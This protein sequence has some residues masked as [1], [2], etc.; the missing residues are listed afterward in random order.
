[1]ENLGLFTFALFSI[2]SKGN[3]GQGDVGEITLCNCDEE[4]LCTETKKKAFD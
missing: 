1:M 4:Y 3:S 2:S